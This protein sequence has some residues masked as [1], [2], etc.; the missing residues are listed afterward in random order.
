VEKFIESVHNE[1]NLNNLGDAK[2][3]KERGI[4]GNVVPLERI[5]NTNSTSII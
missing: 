3:S 5:K 2:T 4:W 1:I